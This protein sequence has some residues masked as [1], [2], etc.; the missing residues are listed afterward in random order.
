MAEGLMRRKRED[1]FDRIFRARYAEIV[2]LS[3]RI[4]GDRAEAED[5][6]QETFVRLSDH[7]IL[8]RPDEEIAAWLRRVA[9]N[10]SFNRRRSGQRRTARE[11]KSPPLEYDSSDEPLP[12]A[13]LSEQRRAVR[14]ALDG[15]PERQRACLLLRHSGYS[16]REIADVTGLAIGSVGVMLTRAE[17]AFRVTY[18]GA[19]HEAV[20]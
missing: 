18:E 15:L 3:S 9:I 13:L 4:L 1:P 10:T 11:R 17:R 6:A 16:Y 7:D 20:S 2:G 5:T 14:V 12:A 19:H 8:H